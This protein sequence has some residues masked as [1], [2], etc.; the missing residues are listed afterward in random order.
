MPLSAPVNSISIDHLPPAWAL[1]RAIAA[2]LRA[3][4]VERFQVGGWGG[5]LLIGVLYPIWDLSLIAL[6]YQGRPDLIHYAVVA[7]AGQA[8]IFTS[9]YNVGEILDRER[10]SGTLPALFL[11][12]CPRLAW[13]GGY[14]LVGLLEA[15]LMATMAL[16]FGHLALGVT[17]DPDL[18]AL[19]LTL[20][21]FIAALTGIGFTLSAIGL[22]IKKANQ[23]SNLIMPIVLVLGGIYYPVALLPDWLRYPA[24][25]LPYGH[26]MQALANAALHHA[27]I[28]QLAPQLLPLAGFALALPVAGAFAFRWLDR[29]VRVRGELE[30][31]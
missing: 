6:V 28:A 18:P 25:A 14:A 21:L 29:L 1:I 7:A 22:V 2:A 17:Y 31:Y 13:L 12:P 19:L 10:L 23:L 5:Y 11:A 16:L 30:V 15:A 24:L 20:A 26:A 8:L 3:R 9:I 27:G 4:A